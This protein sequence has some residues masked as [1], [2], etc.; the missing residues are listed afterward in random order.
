MLVELF[1]EE[2]KKKSKERKKKIVAIETLSC[3][4]IK[5]FLNLV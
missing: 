4:H 2:E 5:L 1:W 3:L